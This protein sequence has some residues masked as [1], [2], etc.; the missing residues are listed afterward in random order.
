MKLKYLALACAFLA[1]S[2]LLNAQTSAMDYPNKSVRLIAPFPPGGAADGVAR[3]VATRLSQL[4]GQSVIVDNR[5]GAGGMIGAEAAARSVGDP[6]ILFLGS[7]GV[8]T[9]NQHIYKEVRYDA[10]KDFTPLSTLVK[11]PS[12]LVVNSTVPA[13]N[14]KE[15]I[16]YAMANPGKLKYG[17]AGNGTSEHTNAVMLGKMAGIDIV[18]V[19]YKGIAPALTD[20][21]GGHINFLVEQGVAILPVIKSNKVKALAVTTAMRSP[22][23]PNVPT[24]NESGVPGFDASAWY[25]LYAPAGIPEAIQKKISQNLGTVMNTPEVKAYFN[26]ISAEVATSTPAELAAFQDYEIK[27]WAEIV[28]SA[29]I[30]TD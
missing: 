16:A 17:S 12:F 19:P 13:N 8:M 25:A 4:W 15:F 1:T 5:P 2:S 20:L 29:N 23:L 24:L 14:V 7:V 30:K 10:V 26:E 18:H 27:R 22:A 6:Y 9:V 21:L 28:K 11:M 3:Q